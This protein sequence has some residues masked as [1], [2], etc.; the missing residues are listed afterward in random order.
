MDQK[1]KN[2]IHSFQEELKKISEY[3]VGIEFKNRWV[4][5]N[6]LPWQ[7]SLL[8]LSQERKK[9]S[10]FYL[11]QLKLKI[12]QIFQQWKEGQENKNFLILPYDPSI[13]HENEKKFHPH[14]INDVID[15]SCQWFAN[16]G[17]QI[18]Q[19]EEIINEELNFDLLNVPKNHPSRVVSDSFYYELTG[20]N[21]KML[22][23][24]TTSN[25]MANLKK[26]AQKEDWEFQLVTFGNVYRNDHDDAT[27]THQFTQID[28]IWVQKTINLANLKWLIQNYLEAVFEQKVKLRYR[29]S[30]FPFTE[31]S[32]EVD[33]G[34]VVCNQQGCRICKLTGWIEVLGTGMLHPYCFMNAGYPY[35][36][37]Y[38]N[39]SVYSYHRVEY[40]GIAGGIGCERI[41]MIKHKINE[42]RD[43]Y[44]NDRKFFEKGKWLC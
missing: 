35:L 27:H 5:E 19:G 22:R 31:T 8:T 16:L 13:Q 9:H 29:P 40:N 6:I 21:K 4:K 43:F 36:P 34:C 14:W 24:H 42:I 2:L 20:D 26:H 38:D 18:E 15:L 30:Y 1:I 17:F 28:F 39:G 3:Q 37:A 7:R 33:L 11:N 32:L 41:A 44:Q 12:N 25:S 23:T 10:G